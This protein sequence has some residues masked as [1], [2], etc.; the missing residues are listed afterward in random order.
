[1]DNVKFVEMQLNKS[2]IVD[3]I[4]FV[5]R[6]YIRVTEED[7]VDIEKIIDYRSPLALCV[8]IGGILEG[9]RDNPNWVFDSYYNKTVG[10][11]F[12]FYCKEGVDRIEFHIFVKEDNVEC[13]LSILNT[14]LK[15][16]MFDYKTIAISDDIP[17]NGIV[18]KEYEFALP[19]GCGDNFIEAIK[20]DGR[21]KWL[22]F[23][24]MPNPL[25][26][27]EWIDPLWLILT[28]AW[29]I[30]TKAQ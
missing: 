28:E 11:Y 20:K 24:G 25:M 2:G 8:K 22:R 5:L 21:G 10:F 3:S 30:L 18:L 19:E 9:K 16:D 4:A 15:A 6:N 7:V 23:D 12:G 17:I 1:M 13:K 27:H 26:P 14:A 29:L